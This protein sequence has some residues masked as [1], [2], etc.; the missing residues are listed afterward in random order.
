MYIQCIYTIYHIRAIIVYIWYCV[1]RGYEIYINTLH[2]YT[3]LL[4]IQRSI[5]RSM[6]KNHVNALNYSNKNLQNYTQ[7]I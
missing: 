3:V 1:Q 2:I 4:Q 6:P 5:F 7:I